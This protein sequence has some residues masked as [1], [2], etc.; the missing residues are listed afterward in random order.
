MKSR[1]IEAIHSEFFAKMESV[2]W[3]EISGTRI[4]WKGDIAVLSFINDINDHMLALEACGK[5]KP[6]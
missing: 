1:Q 2:K 6:D 3:V 4:E 5:A